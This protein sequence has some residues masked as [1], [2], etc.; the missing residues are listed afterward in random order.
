MIGD[1]L[2]SSLLCRHLKEN[3]REPEVHFVANRGTE[4][5]LEGNP[6]IDRIVIFEPAYR[7]SKRA[8]FRFLMHIRR[9]RYDA[10]I[11]AYGKLESTLISVFSGAGT[12]IGYDKWYSRLCYTRT[13]DRKQVGDMEMSMGLGHRLALLQPLFPELVNPNAVPEIHLSREEL[14]QAVA[15][16]E[17][18]GI[19]EN[20]RLIM[21]G[22]LGSERSKT[23]PPDY[24]ALLLRHLAGWLPEHV[25]LLNYIPDQKPAIKI[26]L[27]HCPPE[28][29]NRIKHEIYSPDLRRFLGL[30]ARCEAQIG[31][32]GGAVHMAKALG[33]PTFS[34]FSPW[35]TK[36]AWQTFRGNPAH[37]AV[38]LE[39]FRPELLEGI[40]KKERKRDAGRLYAHFKPEAILPE[41]ERFAYDII[42]PTHKH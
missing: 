1:V 16:L 36:R 5:V 27:E 42:L 24:L 15:L 14:L 13:V 28:I 11:D 40:G 25:F 32:E 38:H 35:I 4:A 23:Y 30:L 39:D 8:F 31:N 9:E 6:H 17:S 34:I 22:V 41:L 3:L 10:V 21:V 20:Q 18:S 12:R 26:F 37:R 33:V 29:R 2:V 7:S 19:R